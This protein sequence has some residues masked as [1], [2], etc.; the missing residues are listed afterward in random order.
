MKN[1]EI[2]KVIYKKVNKAPKIIEIKNDLETKQKLVNG[3]IEVVPY[4][5]NMLIIC[6]EEG[7]IN[8]LKA[9]VLFDYDFI[10]G[11]FIIVGD[12]YE[13]ADFKSLT[14][15]QINKAVEDINKRSIEYKEKNNAQ[16]VEK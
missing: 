7:K 11:D 3:L 8:N 13:N 4:I 9:N 12:D 5:D 10:A 1:E 14:E 16:E 15:K 2:I 6:N